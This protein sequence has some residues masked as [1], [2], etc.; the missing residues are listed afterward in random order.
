MNLQDSTEINVFKNWPTENNLMESNP[1]IIKKMFSKKSE[2]Y[3][4]KTQN[5]RD[6]ISGFCI[7]IWANLTVRQSDLFKK[8][9]N[10]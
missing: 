10:A 2:I 5:Q 6:Q 3:D 9:G 1:E 8:I 7:H 4:I